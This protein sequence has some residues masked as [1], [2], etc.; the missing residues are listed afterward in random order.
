M[1]LSWIQDSA[2]ICQRKAL[3]ISAKLCRVNKSYNW[4]F[5]IIIR[6]SRGNPRLN[7]SNSRLTWNST[8][9]WRRE[10][11]KILMIKTPLSKRMIRSSIMTQMPT[12]TM[13]DIN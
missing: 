10:A 5:T 6:S 11:R 12:E 13:I 7:S 8:T 2:T 3:K 1:T 9:V 4:E